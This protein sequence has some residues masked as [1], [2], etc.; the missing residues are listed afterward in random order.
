[1]AESIEDSSSSNDETLM[2]EDEVNKF[3]SIL[4]QFTPVI[5]ETVTQ[6]YLKQSGVQ[7]DDDRVVKL[8]SA[9][10]QKFMSGKTNGQA[11]ESRLI[12]S[13]TSSTIA[14]S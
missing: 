13:Q 7:T 8:I 2:D 14:S 4:D 10:V 12:S 3:S 1:M 11:N 6:Y 5:P 9:S